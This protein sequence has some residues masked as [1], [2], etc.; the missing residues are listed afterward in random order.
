MKRLF[1][2]LLTL[3]VC[4]SALTGCVSSGKGDETTKEPAADA[5][6]EIK[7]ISID[8]V[9]NGATVIKFS[10]EQVSVDGTAAST[11]PAAAVY[12]ANDIVYYEDGKDFTYGEGTEADAHT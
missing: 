2:L 3:A 8:K 5:A 1:C 4:A 7:A 6:E 9:W 10:D 12:T 11:D